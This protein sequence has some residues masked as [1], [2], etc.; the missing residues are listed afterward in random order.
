MTPKVSI[1]IK[2]FLPPFSIL[3]ILFY[4]R[5]C[6]DEELSHGSCECQL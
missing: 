2:S 3:F 4:E 1:L 6:E 5:V